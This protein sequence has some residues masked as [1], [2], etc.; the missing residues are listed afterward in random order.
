MTTQQAQT[1]E[2]KRQH[3]LDTGFSL[4]FRKGFVGVGLQEILKTSG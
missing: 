1:S 4:V 2:P 3:I